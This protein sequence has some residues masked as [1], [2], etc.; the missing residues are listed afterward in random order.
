[1]IACPIRPRSI[2]VLKTTV[3]QTDTLAGERVLEALTPCKL[4]GPAEFAED[5]LLSRPAVLSFS[6]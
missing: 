2:E 1:M 6:G 5:P 4:L 3:S